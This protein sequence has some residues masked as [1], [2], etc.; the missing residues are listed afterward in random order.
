MNI[1]VAT[2][3]RDTARIFFALLTAVFANACTPSLAH[4]PVSDHEL[5]WVVSGGEDRS[6]LIRPTVQPEQLMALTDDMR[7]FAHRTIAGLS[8]RAEQLDA[9]TAALASDQGLALRYDSEANLSVAEAFGQRRVNCLSYTMLLAALAREVGIAVQFNQVDI[10]PIW[11]LRD[12]GDGYLLYRHVNA[13]V[14]VS[15]SV[16][17]IIDVTPQEY[18]FTF[19]QRVISD[20]QAQAQF[21]N[22]RAMELQSHGDLAAALG[23]ELRA[24]ELDD[25]P[26]FLWTNLS[27]LYLAAGDTKAADIAIR[28]ALKLDPGDASAY[29][30]AAHIYEAMNEPQQAR[31]F[32]RSAEYNL[33]RNPYYHYRLALQAYQQNDDE[34]AYE[35]VRKAAGLY[36]GE[37]R[38][39]FLM[40]VVLARMDQPKL[41]RDSIEVAISLSSDA[42]QQAR[43][44]SKLSRL[45]ARSHQS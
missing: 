5:S 20:R 11:D 30:T 4:R 41:A 25:Q 31:R 18:D 43:Y 23:Y 15:P 39:F 36:P 28:T 14:E 6:T 9:L 45:P 35:E 3:E 8:S 17:R 10:P 2:A 7:E 21:Y 12:N 34:L 1:V 42:T 40:G 27:Y 26:A 22:N 44:R 33:R 29:G 37:H 16:F 32:R 19:P 38:F 13:R 24:I